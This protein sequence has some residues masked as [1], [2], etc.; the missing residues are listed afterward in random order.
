MICRVKVIQDDRLADLKAFSKALGSIKAVLLKTGSLKGMIGVEAAEFMVKNEITLIGTEAMSIEDSS[1]K[2]H[3]VHCALLENETVIVESLNLKD[4]PEGIYTLVCLP[5]KI[6][7]A[8][9]A[10]A[11]AVLIYD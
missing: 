2:S 4:A 1:D 10:P 7:G 5:L 3:P 9:G 8:D 11:R 6:K